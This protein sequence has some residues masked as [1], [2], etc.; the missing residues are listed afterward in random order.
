[1]KLTELEEKQREVISTFRTLM[2]GARDAI[3]ESNSIKELET[4]H[5]TLIKAL[6]EIYLL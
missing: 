2:A 4:V 5:N 6:H 1:M 3:E